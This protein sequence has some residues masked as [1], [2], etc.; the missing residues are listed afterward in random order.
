MAE[1]HEWSNTLGTAGFWL[2]TLGIIGFG[3]P[4]LIM[5]FEQ[6]KIAHNMGYYFARQPDALNH[7]DIWKQITIMPDALVIFGAAIVFYDLVVKIY[8]PKKI[9]A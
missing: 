2:T 5:G 3:I 8:F 6:G 9:A 1:G 4:K 7:M